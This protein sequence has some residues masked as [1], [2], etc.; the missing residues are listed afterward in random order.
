M[1]EAERESDPSLFHSY[2]RLYSQNFFLLLC[3]KVEMTRKSQESR[4]PHTP[5]MEN[6]TNELIIA[7]CIIM[8]AYDC[9]FVCLFVW[10]CG[11]MLL[12]HSIHRWWS[13]SSISHRLWCDMTWCNRLKTSR[14]SRAVRDEEGGDDIN[15]EGRKRRIIIAMGMYVNIN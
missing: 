5:K 6:Q 11:A 1:R 9:L 4:K 2:S 13:S 3:V 10:V 15:F 7:F 8:Y 12:L 14:E